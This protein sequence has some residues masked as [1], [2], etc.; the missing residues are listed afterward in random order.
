MGKTMRFGMSFEGPLNWL[1]LSKFCDNV[2]LKDVWLL[3][4][5]CYLDSF[6]EILYEIMKT[7]QVRFIPYANS[8]FLRHPVLL[9]SGIA[10]I[11][12]IAPGRVAASYC[13]AGYETAVK[14]H[15]PDKDS[16]RACR[17]AIEITRLIWTGKPVD[18]SGKH[19]S[20][21]H[22]NIPYPARKG[23]PIYLATRGRKFKLGGELADG[24]ATHGKAP[25]YLRRMSSHLEE[26]AK[27]SGRDPNRIDRTVI[28]PIFIAKPREAMK[29]RD[30]IRG[31]LGAFVGAEYS[32]DW[33]DTFD[34]GVEEVQPLRNYIRSKS[35]F[36][37]INDLVSDDLLN[38]LV[39]GYAI[40]GTVEECID[41][42]EQMRKNGAS[43]VIPMILDRWF[44]T[45]SSARKY[46]S[47]FNKEIVQAFGD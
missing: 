18:Y 21:S 45:T 17:E 6:S 2:G 11:D 35:S 19:W 24:V 5:M 31:M 41:E 22:V 37:G 1:N 27:I 46:I 9:A 44:P 8:V 25:K 30:S 13:S 42:V 3:A 36:E 32:L 28:L 39:D 16:V 15:I 23:I 20:L 47:L 40:V 4:D 12:R 34:I 10:N 7:K 33:L 26:G 29:V 14:L 38:R 43:T